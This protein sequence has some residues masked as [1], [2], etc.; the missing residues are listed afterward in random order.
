MLV[1]A[2]IVEVALSTMRNPPPRGRALLA[3]AMLGA[4][5]DVDIILGILLGRGGTLHGTATHSFTAVALWAAVGTLLGG[6]RW[7]AVFGLGYAS[8]LLMDLLDESGPTNLMLLW[9]FSGQ[10]PYSLGKLFP[11]VP[12]LGDGVVDTIRHTLRPESLLLLFQQT[13]LAGVFAAL[14]VLLAAV[15]RRRRTRVAASG[16]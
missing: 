6:G 4:L 14:L 2:G 13:A 16:R 5:P 11:K 1:G 12:V 9:P 7:G 3:G 10:R 8:H 15:L